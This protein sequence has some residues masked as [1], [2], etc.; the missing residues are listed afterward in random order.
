MIYSMTLF[1]AFQNLSAEEEAEA[2]LL[3]L[4]RILRWK[5]RSRRISN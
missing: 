3:D 5:C 1:K 2:N 4:K